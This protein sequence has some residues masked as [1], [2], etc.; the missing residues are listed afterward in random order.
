[1]P[2]YGTSGRKKKRKH[3]RGRT[4]TPHRA[5]GHNHATPLCQHAKTWTGK[6]GARTEPA[7]SESRTDTAPQINTSH[8]QNN[9]GP[10]IR[11]VQ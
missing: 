8:L 4:P 10:V 5:P 6:P 7:Q 11:P 9:G 3:K 2:K 1:M